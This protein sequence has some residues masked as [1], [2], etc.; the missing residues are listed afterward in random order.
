MYVCMKPTCTVPAATTDSRVQKLPGVR[1]GAYT[2]LA[3][4]SQSGFR[5][6]ISTAAVLLPFLPIYL[7]C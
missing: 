4:P 1:G 3:I 5:A 2:G 7:V 6:H